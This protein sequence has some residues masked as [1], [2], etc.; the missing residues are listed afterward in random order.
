MEDNVKS[1]LEKIQEIKNQK[2]KVWA[3]S[4]KKEIDCQKLTFKQQKDLISTIGDGTIGALKLQKILNDIVLANTENND[5]V[6]TDRLGIVL[7]LRSNAI[8]EFIKDGDDEFPLTIFINRFRNTEFVTSKTINGP[9]TIEVKVP[10]L[11]AENKVIQASMESVKKD[12]DDELGK[13]IGNIYTY[14]IVKY[15]ESVKFGESELKFADLWIKDRF[16]I[17]ENL[18]LS[19]NKEII[20]FIQDIKTKE[21]EVLKYVV[22]GNTKNIN[23]DVSFFDS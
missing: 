18:P 14:E 21:N 12:T 20:S 4:L 11:I 16:K 10:T 13:S 15:I 3:N 5:L 8:S 2:S 19:I 23:I 17:V 7:E 1:F 6:T 9:I 22:N